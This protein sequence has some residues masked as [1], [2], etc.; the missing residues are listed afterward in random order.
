MKF[1]T[2]SSGESLSDEVRLPEG[3][4]LTGVMIPADWDTTADGC[5]FQISIDG[6]TYANAYDETGTEIIF[7]V[8]ADTWVRLPEMGAARFIKFRSGGASTAV[9]QSA[10]RILYLSVSNI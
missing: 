5:S 8:E 4:Y 1:A 3:F 10:D 2:I 9:T 7:K 6:S